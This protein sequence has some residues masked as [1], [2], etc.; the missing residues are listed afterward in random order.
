MFAQTVKFKEQP[1]LITVKIA[2]DLFINTTS[3]QN[4]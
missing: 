2:T 3:T 4:G 1:K